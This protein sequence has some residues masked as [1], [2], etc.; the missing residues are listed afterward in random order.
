MNIEKPIRKRHSYSQH[1]KAGR[2]VVFPLLCPVSEKNWVPGWNPEK[3]ISNS[4]VA[5]HD[6][7]FVTSTEK[8]SSIWIVSKYDQVNYGLEMYKVTPQHTVGKLEISLEPTSEN[9][10][11]AHISYEFTALD[12]SGADFL[13]EFT[14]EWYVE[15][16]QGWEK[17]MN[18][19]IATGKKIT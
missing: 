11:I 19:Y 17:A 15:F 8:E 7:I 14:E 3:V 2:E 12:K 10:T 1:I 4:G 6:C 18:H 9:L 5:E 16:M 13:I